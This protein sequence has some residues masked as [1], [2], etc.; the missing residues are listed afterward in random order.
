[1]KSFKRKDREAS[2]GDDD[3]DS[4]SGTSQS[5]QAKPKG[6][7]AEPDFHGEKRTNATHGSTTK[8]R[9]QAAKLYHMAHVR[10]ENRHGLVVD[11]MLTHATG[12]AER[13]AALTMLSRMKERHRITL[14]ADKTYNTA[15][16]VAVLRDIGVTQHVAQNKT[17]R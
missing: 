11:A 16:F 17:H 12:T 10:M 1:M 6:R 13:E 9:G 5:G 14:A 15:Q 2:G 3:D 8:A 4:A 7:N